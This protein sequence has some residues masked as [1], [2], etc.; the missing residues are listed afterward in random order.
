[1][2]VLEVCAFKE[3]LSENVA[4]FVMEQKNALQRCGVE[5]DWFLVRGK[6]IRG[7]VKQ[8]RP[9]KKKIAVFR[10]DVIH[11]HYGLC[12]L[13]ANLQRKVPVVTTYHGSDINDP[14]AFRFS[15]IAIRLSAWNIFVSRK[16]MEM[17]HVQERCSLIPCGIDLED[18]Q[19]VEKKEA[20]RM[21]HLDDVKRYV[22][23]AGAFDNPVKN[24][25]LAKEVVACLHNDMVE[26]LELKGYSREEVTLLMCAADALLMTS[27][28]EGSPQVIKEA[29]ACGC[30]IVSVDVGDVRERIEGV[31]GCFV[32]PSRVPK[33][34][35]DLLERAMGFEGKTNG[36]DHIVT[37]GLDNRQV[38]ERLIGIY[39]ALLHQ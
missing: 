8:L 32:T 22:L 26:M 25:P 39:I 16:N 17:A 28:S 31:E 20:R 27:F 23:F 19:W 24:A 7:Y 4:P 35:A 14:K 10:P 34:I 2:R 36:R 13:L 12:G 29:L 15:K 18:S 11:A 3:D 9:L 6:G 33:E 38:A 21:M 30:P 37:L 5:C 1:M